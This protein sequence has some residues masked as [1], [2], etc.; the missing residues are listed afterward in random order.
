MPPEQKAI[1]ISKTMEKSLKKIASTYGLVLGAVL[2][3][4]A[5]I[6]YL[7]NLDLFVK[8][9]FGLTI[10]GICIVGGF[11]SLFRIKLLNSGVL[12]F[13]D[14]FTAYFIAA[15][16]GISLYTFSTYVMFNFFDSEAANYVQQKSFAMWV[17]SAK[18]GGMTADKIAEV[19]DQM[20]NGNLFSLGNSLQALA[21]YIVWLSIVGLLLAA[22]FQK[23]STQN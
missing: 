5:I 23:K 22:T 20:K 8:P 9:L 3:L 13:R 1:S 10:F 11:I 17:E 14:C 19:K 4:M 6:A 7:K 18:L 15:V 2:V 21:L 12:S 16:L